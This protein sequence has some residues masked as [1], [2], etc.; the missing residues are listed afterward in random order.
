MGL[1]KL[2]KAAISLIAFCLR[3]VLV[4]LLFGAPP[5]TFRRMVCVSTPHFRQI[6]PV[7]RIVF[8][9]FDGLRVYNAAQTAQK[10]RTTATEVKVDPV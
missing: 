10:R 1:P 6:K 8:Y 2:K 5:R 3:I 4:V 9:D 7:S